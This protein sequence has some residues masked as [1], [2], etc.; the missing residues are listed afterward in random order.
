MS[1]STKRMSRDERGLLTTEFA[2]LL[3]VIMLIA[4]AAILM[5]Q[6]VRHESRAQSAADAAAR[7]ASFYVDDQAGGE[8]AGEAAASIACRGTISGIDF[9]WTEPVAN[10]FTPGRVVATVVCS[11]R[12]EGWDILR[13]STTRDVTARSVATLEYWRATP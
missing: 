3:P 11:D 1:Q 4:L 7:A 9:D 5:T 6:L 2:I 12:F 8:S 13:G 10:T